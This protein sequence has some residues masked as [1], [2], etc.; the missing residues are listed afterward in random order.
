MTENELHALVREL[1]ASSPLGQLS[2]M[3]ARTVFELL[4]QRGYGITKPPTPNK[5][6]ENHHG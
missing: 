1:Q 6:I 3:E 4:Q 2:S 5:E